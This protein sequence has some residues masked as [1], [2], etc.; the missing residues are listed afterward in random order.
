M[1][2]CRECGAPMD[3]SDAFCAHCGT[4]VAGPDQVADR[5][6]GRSAEPSGAAGQS[7]NRHAAG[8]R[9]AGRARDG[10][11]RSATEPARPASDEDLLQEREGGLDFATYYPTN[12]GWGPLLLSGLLVILSFL[13]VPAILLLGYGYR[14]GRAAALGRPTPPEFHDWGGLFFDGLRMAVLFVLAGL[15]WF[16]LAIAVLTPVMAVFGEGVI[17]GLVTYATIPLLYYVVGLF[18]TAF[19]GSD[20]VIGAFTDGRVTTLLG[21]QY[22]FTSAIWG[23]IWYFVLSVMT[24]VLVLTVVGWLWGYGYTVLSMSAFWGYVHYRAVQKGVLDPPVD[25][26][27]T[28]DPTAGHVAGQP[29][30]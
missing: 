18:V 11:Q 17:A 21:S 7:A 9:S 16:V 3:E 13:L 23:I 6:A 29:T 27:P 8:D 28:A 22:F 19:V 26:D 10:R 24:G 25:D 20:S 15:V 30:R 14:V 4:E 1:A 5:D 12:G 2:Y